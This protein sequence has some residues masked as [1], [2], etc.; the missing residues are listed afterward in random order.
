[1]LNLI[2]KVREGSNKSL[3]K[4][5]L[6][7]AL[8]FLAEKHSIDMVKRNYFD[9]LNP[10]GRTPGIR[11]KL[12]GF[13]YLVGQNIAIGN[14]ISQIHNILMKSSDN[15]NNTIN[16]KWTRCGIGF[17]YDLNKEIYTTI[18]FSVRDLK[19]NPIS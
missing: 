11:A 17:Q 5:Y 12:V 7:D 13:N 1:M 4:L 10:D 3:A 15:Y 2:N 14:N 6:D 8:N 9:H 16:P 19:A 18:L